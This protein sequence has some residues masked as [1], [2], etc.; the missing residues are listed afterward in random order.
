MM[1]RVREES[2]YSRL[3]I[4]ISNV[5]LVLLINAQNPDETSNGG[6]RARF[7]RGSTCK[8]ELLVVG[9]HLKVI[10]LLSVW[11]KACPWDEQRQLKLPKLLEDKGE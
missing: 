6:S 4:N 11:A 10:E 1:N 8:G 7:Y 5:L 3:K 9:R 2:E